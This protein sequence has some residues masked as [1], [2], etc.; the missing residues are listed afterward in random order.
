MDNRKMQKRLSIVVML[1]VLQNCASPH[2][3]N[4]EEITIDAPLTE[5]QKREL[6]ERHGGLP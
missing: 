3:Y 5:H 6:F 2:K 4:F 1:V